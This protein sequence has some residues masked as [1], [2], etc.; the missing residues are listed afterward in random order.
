MQQIASALTELD[1]QADALR[2][3]IA[4]LETIGVC[5]G[6]EYWR[7][8]ENGRQAKLYCNHITDQVCPLHGKPK[9]GKRI[10]AYIGADLDKQAQAQQAIQRQKQKD[11]LIEQISQLDSQRRSIEQ[12]ITN[13]WCAA[14]G[15]WAWQ[16]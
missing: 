16:G 12:P 7:D 9:K 15:N 10:Q 14:T 3:Q 6:V 5:T 8:R 13:A 1:R 4:D 11:D 2:T